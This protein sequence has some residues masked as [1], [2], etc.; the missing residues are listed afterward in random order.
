V[1]LYSNFVI[2]RLIIVVI[3][4]G[5]SVLTGSCGRS[6]VTFA[7]PVQKPLDLGKDP[8][9]LGPFIAMDDPSADEYIVRD[10]N[11][12]RDPHRW[13]FLHPEM[14]FRIPEAGYSK[15]ALEFAI[16]DVTYKV[17]GP[18]TVSAAIDGKDL[19]SIR[20]DHPGDYRMEKPVPPGLLTPGKEVHVTFNAHPRW[21]SPEDRAELSFY[22]RSAGFIR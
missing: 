4:G 12:G 22:L 1:L 17:T 8:E 16:I 20:C 14:R 3:V 21:V 6:P 19:G 7:V 2:R 13:A 11:P 15:F 9:G 10:I 18:V 5:I